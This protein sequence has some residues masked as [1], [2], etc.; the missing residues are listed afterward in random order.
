MIMVNR[1]ITLMTLVAGVVL[2]VMM[3]FTT[4]TEIGPVGVL[5]FFTTAYMIVYGLVMGVMGLFGRA[6]G[7]K[8]RTKDYVKGAIIAFG[9]MMIAMSQ[10]MRSLSWPTLGL[11]VV[12]VGMA[13]F[14][15]EKRM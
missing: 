10:S 5:V 4:P 7:K 6:T 12:F 14:L 9:P 11:V 3:N 15:V 13:C 1:V 8:M 2:T